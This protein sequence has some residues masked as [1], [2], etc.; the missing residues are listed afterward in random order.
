MG[1]DVFYPEDRGSIFLRDFI[2]YI[3]NCNAIS[4]M[5]WNVMFALYSMLQWKTAVSI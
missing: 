4:P 5:I 2:L 3:R 1:R